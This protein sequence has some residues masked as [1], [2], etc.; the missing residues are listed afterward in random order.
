MEFI[1]GITVLSEST[2]VMTWWGALGWAIVVAVIA[3]CILGVMEKE[4]SIGVLCGIVMLVVTFFVIYIPNRKPDT[5][6]K[7]L[8]DESISM[9]NFDEL[10]E[11]VGHEGDM[12]LIKIKEQNK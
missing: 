6:Y 1:D 3:G 5:T 10:Y 8:I 7:V 2:F 9:K 12:I 11:V 4:W